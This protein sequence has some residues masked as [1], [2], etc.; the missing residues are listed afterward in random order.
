MSFISKICA[1]AIEKG[2]SF[3]KYSR[4][5]LKTN[6]ANVFESRGATNPIANVVPHALVAE[7]KQGPK[8]IQ[9]I[10]GLSKTQSRELFE[11]LPEVVRE[12]FD[13]L[14]Q[15]GKK[16]GFLE[17]DK[18]GKY[19]ANSMK[20]FLSTFDKDAYQKML[21][22]EQNFSGLSKAD[23]RK[24]LN[25]YKTPEKILENKAN[26]QRWLK[27]KDQ[28]YEYSRILEEEGAKKAQQAA[29]EIEEIFGV[30][31]EFRGKG[32]ESIYDKL[33]R[34]V[35]KGK[36]I[37]DINGAKDQVLDLVGTRL[38]LDDVSE[39][40]IQRIVDNICKGIE[41]GKISIT[42]IH[43][44]SKASQPYFSAE[45][46]EQIRKAA[47]RK[48][49]EIPRLEMEQTS[50]SGYVSAQM[51]IAHSNGVNGE[52]QIKGKLMHKYSEIEHIPYDSRMGKNLGKNNPLL[53]QLFE[54][55]ETAVHRLKRNGLDKSYDDYI[56]ECYQY[57]RKFEQGKIKGDFKLP[58]LP[59]ELKEYSVLSFEN[60][61][62]IHTQANAIKKSIQNSKRAVA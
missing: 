30:K 6:P 28:L 41:S 38:I 50:A 47:A 51:N 5:M 54:P 60:L 61:D 7:A 3:F 37:K 32:I 55:V 21:I 58:Q 31:P 17:V 24:L 49:Y 62:K 53:E 52:L 13:T 11:Y 16:L 29:D 34:Q 4:R 2:R 59:D 57:I 45:Q 40:G 18:A 9:E 8:F 10:T 46:F 12:N 56:L 36:E 33:S 48:G 44:Y 42:K 26:I 39:Q 25:A 14:L 35:L 23:Y 22:L 20:K 27:C 43:N 1:Y 19:T 15:S